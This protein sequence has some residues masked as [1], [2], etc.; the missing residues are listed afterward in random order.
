MSVRDDCLQANAQYA[1]FFPLKHL[2]KVPAKRL[3]VVTC[4]DARM[5][6]A[7]LLGLAPGDAHIFR[8]AGG[9]VTDDALR[10][11]VLSHKLLGTREFFVINHTGCAM[12]GL[13]ETAFRDELRG[14]SGAA[15]IEMRFYAFDD[16][17]GNVRAQVDKIKTCPFISGD[18]PVSG[19]VYE[20][21]SGQLRAVAGA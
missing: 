7:E 11:L 12:Q 8:N 9:I 2:P 3:A 15:E 6:P 19:F 20:V 10:S 18:S 21:E 4:M 13:E 5:Q 1:A 14:E 17:D 16:I